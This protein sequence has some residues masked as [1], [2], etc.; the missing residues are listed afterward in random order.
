MEKNNSKK[1]FCIYVRNGQGKPYILSSYSSFREAFIALNNIIDYEKERGRIFYVD[2][3][4]YDNKYPLNLS[5]KYLCIMQRSITDWQKY[6]SSIFS[7]SKNK[8]DN[9]FIFRQEM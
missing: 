8:N 7:A 3:D 6:E 4:F 9:I 1:E 2:N 5:G